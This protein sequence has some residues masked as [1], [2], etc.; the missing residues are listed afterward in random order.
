MKT[1]NSLLTKYFQKTK[2][3]STVRFILEFSVV[4]IFL[5]IASLTLVAILFSFFNIPL[6]PTQPQFSE[7]EIKQPLL[8]IF[9]S[10]IFAP[11]VETFLFQMMPT[12][13][14]SKLKVGERS[15]MILLGLLFA[16]AHLYTGFFGFVATL[17]LGIF[18]V[19]IYHLKSKQSQKQAFFNVAAIH[20]L[21]NLSA[22]AALLLSTR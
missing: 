16:S 11:I 21:H 4:S 10:S 6:L 19:W 20:S 2:H 8:L 22:T 12:M 14:L 3:Y 5:K 18:W 17:P 1:G 7:S 9:D 13:I 15:Q